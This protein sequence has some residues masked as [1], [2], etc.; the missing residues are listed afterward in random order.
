MIALSNGLHSSP[1]FPRVTDFGHFDLILAADVVWLDDLVE[2]L[3]KTMRRLTDLGRGT[4]V[5]GGTIRMEPV[6]SET[7]GTPSAVANDDGAAMRGQCDV[8]EQTEVVMAY[9]WRSDATGRFLLR[10]LGKN[11]VVREILPEVHR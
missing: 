9:Q 7:K 3:V 4:K 5:P 2:P 6:A 10:E 8:K 1:A 11:F